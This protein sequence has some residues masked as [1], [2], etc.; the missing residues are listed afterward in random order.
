MEFSSEATLELDR[1]FG[2]ELGQAAS[3]L[4]NPVRELA[5]RAE[6]FK[7][8][9]RPTRP[10]KV[11]GTFISQN[12]ERLLGI[13]RLIKRQASKNEE[14]AKQAVKETLVQEAQ[15]PSQAAEVVSENLVAATLSANE[16]QA[17][18]LLNQT[19]EATTLSGKN[20]K[21]FV[22]FVE[23]TG[24]ELVPVS[25]IIEAEYMGIEAEPE[26]AEYTPP[27]GPP[28]RPPEGPRR[29][30]GFGRGGRRDR[31][32]REAFG[33]RRRMPLVTAGFVAA[34]L[35]LS[36]ITGQGKPWE[37]YPIQWGFDVLGMAGSGT[38]TGTEMLGRGAIGVE[39]ISGRDRRIIG[40]QIERIFEGSHSARDLFIYFL[41]VRGDEEDTPIKNMNV[42][43][44]PDEYNSRMNLVMLLLGKEI[45]KRK[46]A[47]NQIAGELVKI[48][49]PKD[50]SEFL[51]L[52]YLKWED[53]R[54]KKAQSHQLNLSQIEEIKN[55]FEKE[56]GLE[57]TRGK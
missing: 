21:D 48:G 29:R 45:E 18:N 32:A 44:D 11:L 28:G 10:V 27:S 41:R 12:Q 25:P 26:E 40:D 14:L 16:R 17:R 19:L 42:V 39:T 4:R 53:F 6:K 57:W 23:G 56:T 54:G 20:K 33:R 55:W 13:V 3:E 50:P 43:G 9:K 51:E 8:Q 35:G 49:Q 46:I 7:E 1:H 38:K 36:V 2:K 52:S 24:R 31:T 15:I 34:I 37:G 22:N 47:P 30:F 5:K